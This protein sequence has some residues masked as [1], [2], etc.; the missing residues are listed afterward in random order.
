MA[1]QNNYIKHTFV[2]NFKTTQNEEQRTSSKN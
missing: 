2:Q 1:Q